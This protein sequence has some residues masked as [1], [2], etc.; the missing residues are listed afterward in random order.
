MLLLFLLEEMKM[1]LIL[2]LM[3]INLL[4]YLANIKGFS[5]NIRF[6]LKYHD[7]PENART[8]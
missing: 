2:G 1:N 8:S 4:S 5:Y 3:E 7:V 6:Y